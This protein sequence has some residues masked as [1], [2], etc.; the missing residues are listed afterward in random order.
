[1]ER[2]N[3]CYFGNFPIHKIKT[4]IREFYDKYNFECNEQ[5][6]QY[7]TFCLKTESILTPETCCTG[8][9]ALRNKE[10]ENKDDMV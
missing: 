1:M 4:W 7:C 9:S 10:K 2:A 3:R 6:E 8:C 5:E